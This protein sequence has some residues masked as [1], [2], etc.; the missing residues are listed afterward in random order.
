MGKGLRSGPGGS[1]GRGLRLH[2]RGR[3]GGGLRT[4]SFQPTVCILSPAPGFG[5]VWRDERRRDTPPPLPGTQ[6]VFMNPHLIFF[7]CQLWGLDSI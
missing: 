3:G 4:R 1:S 2:K 5:D 6:R 7:I